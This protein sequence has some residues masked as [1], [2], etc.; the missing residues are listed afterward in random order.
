[1]KKV[2]E[3]IVLGLLLSGTA[4]AEIRQIEKGRAEFF[5]GY[6]SSGV[7]TLCVDG[8][9]FVVVRGP[10]AISVTQAFEIREGQSLPTEC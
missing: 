8:Y 6:D 2:I 3:I 7:T 9:K 1:M 5:G 10:K 4:Y